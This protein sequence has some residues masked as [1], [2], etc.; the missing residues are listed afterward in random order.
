MPEQVGAHELCGVCLCGGS[1]CV[2]VC[3]YVFVRGICMC[4][5]CV[6]RCVLV[7]NG[8]IELYSAVSINPQPA[9]H[10]LDAHNTYIVIIY[11]CSIVYDKV[12]M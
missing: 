1:V 10:A 12:P 6:S 11:A 2:C 5:L 4:V 9:P 3:V 7:L 8:L